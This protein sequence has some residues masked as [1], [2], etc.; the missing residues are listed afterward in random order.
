MS[1]RTFD[2]S[3]GEYYHIYS[4]GVEKRKIFLSDKD[5]DRFTFLLYVANSEK[6]IH[7]SDHKNKTLSEIKKDVPLVAVGAWCLMP[8]HFHLLLKEIKANGISRYLQRLLT[9]Y[10]M[11]FNKRHN[12]KGPLFEGKFKA[13]HLRG[14][15][16][17]KYQYAYIHLNPVGIIDNGWKMKNIDNK[18]RAESFIDSYEYSSY[19]DYKGEKRD[20]G[21]ILQPEVFPGYFESTTDFKSMMLEWLN[22]RQDVNVKARP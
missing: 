21:L 5:S 16:D 11:Y 9:G 4:R 19:Q 14:D 22:F 17:L 13:R 12:H 18:K 1:S 15:E 6:S 8:N 10:S 2:F 3:I 7:L 20:F